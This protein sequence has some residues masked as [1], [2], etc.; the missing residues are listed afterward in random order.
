[1]KRNAVAFVFDDH[2][3][4]EGV[5]AG[6][7]H[8][9]TLYALD[10][11]GPFGITFGCPCGCGALHGASFDNRPA[12]WV[13]KNTPGHTGWH[14]DGNKDKPTLTPSLG[15]HVSK[16]INE[17]G[18]DGVYHWHGFLKAGIFEEC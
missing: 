3:S 14:W 4:H 18:P 8:W 1:M 2:M 10:D 16:G 9:T 6:G 12:D 15:L 7:F 13:A 11:P 17:V 5:P